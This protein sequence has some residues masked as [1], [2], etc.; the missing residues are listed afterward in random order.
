[1]KRDV[2]AYRPPHA[3]SGAVEQPPGFGL[4]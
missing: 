1:V 3:V 2:H 4:G